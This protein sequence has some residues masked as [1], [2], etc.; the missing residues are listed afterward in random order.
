MKVFCI[1]SD[2]RA[3]QLKSPEVFS[4]ILK[5]SGIRG[6]YVPFRVR[7]ADLG[8]AIQSLNV[9]NIAG[10]NVTVPFKEAAVPHMDVLSEGANIIGAINTIVINEGRLKGY[11]TNAIGF[12][13]ALAD[14]RFEV[15]GCRAVVLGTGGAARAAVFILSWLRSAELTVAGRSREKAA[16][17]TRDFRGRAVSLAELAAEPV[18]ADLIVNAT[19]VSSTKESPELARFAQRLKADRCRLV[20][21]LNYGRRENIW[22]GAAARIGA[23]FTDGLRTLAFQAR[24]TFALWTGIQVPSEE[25]VKALEPFDAVRTTTEALI[26]GQCV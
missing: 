14:L 16:R 7:V 26:P 20:F 4:R 3:G 13:D 11:N 2:E 9:L 5:R 22:E 1:L 25:F 15:D 10:A 18:A 12:M 19:S 6:A 23:E 24:R 21:D 8:R 17:L